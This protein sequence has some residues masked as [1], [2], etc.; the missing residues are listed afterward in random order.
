MGNLVDLDELWLRHNQL[1]G[2]I[3]AELGNLSSLTVLGLE[4][5][6]L[7]GEIPAALDGLVN[8]RRLF[9]AGNDFTGCVPATLAEG[10]R[11]D[12]DELGLPLCEPA[13]DEEGSAGGGLAFQAALPPNLTV[14][15]GPH[16][17]SR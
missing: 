15:E 6:Q 1:S 10:T 13:A 2:T 3:P 4:Q 8:L 12:I 17:D 7:T 14:S 5:N 9:L 16:L 11:N